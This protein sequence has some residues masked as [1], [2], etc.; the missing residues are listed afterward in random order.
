MLHL[1]KSRFILPNMAS[2]T[3]E[4]VLPVVSAIEQLNLCSITES[5]PQSPSQGEEMA[6][7]KDPLQQEMDVSLLYLFVRG[8]LKYRPQAFCYGQWYSPGPCMNPLMFIL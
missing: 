1:E 4:F 7:E 6:T 2:M 3:S 5:P 8:F